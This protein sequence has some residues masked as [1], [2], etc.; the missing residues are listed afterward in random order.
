VY[1]VPVNDT[2]D[3]QLEVSYLPPAND[4]VDFTLLPSYTVPGNDDVDFTLGTDPS[5]LGAIKIQTADGS[6]ELP[7]YPI[8]TSKNGVR[9][10]FRIGT[11]DGKGFIPVTTLQTL[12]TPS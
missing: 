7:I 4:S 2:T 11:E 12:L 10:F 1:S 8:D 9:E 6:V 5:P 3:F